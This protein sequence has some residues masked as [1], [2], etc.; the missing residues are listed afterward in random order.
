MAAIA[1]KLIG[2]RKL[3]VPDFNS[4]AKDHAIKGGKKK[5]NSFKLFWY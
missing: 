1:R 5:K 3:T 4:E 2:L